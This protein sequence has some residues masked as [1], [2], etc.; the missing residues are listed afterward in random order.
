MAAYLFVVERVGIYK[1]NSG[2]FPRY[3]VIQ[4]PSYWVKSFLF[5]YDGPT[6]KG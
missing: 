2:Y 3:M 5:S 4:Y 1:G 6:L